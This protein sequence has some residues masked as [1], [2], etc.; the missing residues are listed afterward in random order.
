M[1]EVNWTQEHMLEVGLNEPDD[2]LKVR[3]TL[4]RIGVASRKERKLYQSCHILHKQGRYYI[5]HFKELFALDGKHANLTQNDI[6]RR[7]RIVQLLVDWG[8]VDIL[9]GDKI[10]D[11]ADQ[12]AESMYGKDFY[13]LSGRQ[14]SEVYEKAIVELDEM[15]ADR[16]DMMRKGEAD[17]GRIKLEA[18]GYLDYIRAVKELG[19]KPISI[20]EFK[21]L[22]SAMGIQ[23]IIKLTERMNMVNKKI[24]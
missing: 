5:V 3:E 21:S 22:Q 8:L 9:N 10:Q 7:N 13:D 16:A 12:L 19:F 24:D 14:Q 23:D 20:D 2:F 15:M 1:E 11:I 18:G 4:S 17:G 6:Q